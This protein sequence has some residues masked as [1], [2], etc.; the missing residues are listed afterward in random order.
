[1]GSLV[2]YEQSVMAEVIYL[3]LKRQGAQKRD[4]EQQITAFQLLFFTGVRYE[5]NPESA[6]VSG[7]EHTPTKTPTR[8]KI[9]KA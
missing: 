2:G 1:L 5:R 7:V 9:R 3:D 8:K 6:E 4:T